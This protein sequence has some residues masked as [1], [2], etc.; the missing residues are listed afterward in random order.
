M[1]G[2][3]VAGETLGGCFFLEVCGK[4]VADK[5]GVMLHNAGRERSEL[6]VIVVFITV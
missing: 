1:L 3:G 2:R 6:S 4:F 5:R